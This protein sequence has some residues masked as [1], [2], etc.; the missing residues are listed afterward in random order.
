MAAAESR[1]EGRDAPAPNV[2]P[3]KPARRGKAKFVFAG[4]LLVAT[5]GATGSFLHGRG[6]ES[7]DDAQVEGRLHNVA[8]RI[9]GRVAKVNVVDNQLVEQGAVIFELEDDQQAAKVEAARADLLAAKAQLAAARAQLGLTEKSAAATLKQ[10]KGGIS[11]AAG[12]LASSSASLVQAKSDV[13]AA[14]SRKKLAE[15]DL[16]RV[17][18]LWELGV[19]SQADLDARQSAF[20]QAVASYDAA[21]ARLIMAEGGTTSSAGGVDVAKARLE[22]AS[23]IDEQIELAK[24]AVGVSEAR[25]KQAE[26]ALRLTELDFEWTK[27]KAPAKGVVSRRNV[28]VGQMVDPGRPLLA[29]VPVDDVWVVANFKEDQ[30]A[31]MKPGQHVELTIDTYGSK[32]F[33]AHVDSMAGASGARFALLPPDNATGNFTKVVQ[34]I[35]VLIRF[36]TKPTVPLRPGMSVNVTVHTK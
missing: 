33:S 13:V 26:A 5:T 16:K 23:T 17:K 30:L 35:P 36:D 19:A 9:S 34:R 20:D 22:S 12:T 14:E 11:Q 25:V 8:S 27:V 10:A 6:R 18:S 24:A 28:E 3:M 7:T 29:I 4:L 32:P 15:S 31:E 2:V 21:R 1:N